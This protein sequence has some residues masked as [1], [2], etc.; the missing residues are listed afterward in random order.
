MSQFSEDCLF[1]IPVL[2]SHKN[3]LDSLISVYCYNPLSRKIFKKKK[4]QKRAYFS[5]SEISGV[6]KLFKKKRMLDILLW[7]KK[8]DKE[9]WWIQC[10]KENNQNLKLKQKLKIREDKRN[11]SIWVDRPL[12]ARKGGTEGKEIWKEIK[13]FKSTEIAWKLREGW[14]NCQKKWSLAEDEKSHTG[15]SWTT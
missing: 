6:L 9:D 12:T 5:L 4:G 15:Y 7:E 14:N 2:Y 11:Q 13:Y 1:N 8:Q 3:Y 10:C